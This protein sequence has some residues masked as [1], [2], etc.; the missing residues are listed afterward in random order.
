MSSTSI[1]RLDSR[2][3][4]PTG[5]KPYHRNTPNFL[6]LNDHSQGAA[7]PGILQGPDL[8]SQPGFPTHAQYQCVETSYISALTPRRQAKALIS[9]A[10]LDRIWDVLC[11]P[12][13]GENS[14]FRFWARKMFTLGKDPRP[15]TTGDTLLPPPHAVLIHDKRIVA[16]QEQ[17]YPLL[18]YY[19]GIT[20]HGGRDR[21]CAEIRQYHCWI[22]KELVARFIKACPTCAL[23]KTGNFEL[24]NIAAGM[25]NDP[26]GEEIHPPVRHLCD[27]VHQSSS[28]ESLYG[29][30]K[31]QNMPFGDEPLDDRFA[32]LASRSVSFNDPFASTSRPPLSPRL[33]SSSSSLSHGDPQSHSMSREVSLYKG[34]PNGWQFHTDYPTAHADFLKD[35]DHRDIHVQRARDS[36]PRIPSIAPLLGLNPH[37]YS[38][39]GKENRNDAFDNRYELCSSQ[40]FG[41]AESSQWDSANIDPALLA[42]SSSPSANRR[43]GL[44][45]SSSSSSSIA[46][47]HQALAP[48]PSLST[49][50]FPSSSSLSTAHRA[51]APP[52][53]D[54]KALSAH[55]SIQSLLQHRG[56]GESSLTPGTPVSPRVFA[57]PNDLSPATSIGFASESAAYPRPAVQ[58]DDGLCKTLAESAGALRLS[59]IVSPEV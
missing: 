32:G 29:A 22:P 13:P 39:S 51:Q 56:D 36:R 15:T 11:Y 52:P 34:L 25:K 30:D 7:G 1:R 47:I 28:H 38:N 57:D 26:D 8:P 12:S 21:T 5:S 59:A 4:S 2:R 40:S 3:V 10:L 16:I 43:P 31:K 19:H 37:R 50:S 48:P 45:D 44:S 23:R 6:A 58:G 17:L 18:C 24:M 49:S 55:L 46:S 33:L 35:K 20:G 14:Q 27:M 41:S 54:L 42:L 53:L 9:Q